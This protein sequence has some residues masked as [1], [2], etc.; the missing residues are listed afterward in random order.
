VV[1]R[2]V[3]VSLAILCLLSLMSITGL[4]HVVKADGG[5]IYINAD[6]SISPSTAPIH[7]SDN[8]TYSLTGDVTTDYY[9]IV[10]ERGNVVLDGAGYTV[11]ASGSGNR[12]PLSQSTGVTISASTKNVTINHMAIT[13]FTYGIYF[14]SSGNTLSGNNVTNNDYGIFTAQSSNNTLSGNNVTANSVAGIMFDF[15]SG[16]TLSDNTVTANNWSILLFSSSGFKVGSSNNTLSG[17]YVANNEYG[18]SLDYFAKNNVLSGNNVTA[19][20]Y[21][22]IG[23]SDFSSGNTLSGNYLT[24]NTYDGIDIYTSSGNLLSGN[25]VTANKGY[26]ISIAFSSNNT[27]SGNNFTANSKA[28]I[29]LDNYPN[30]PYPTN[31]NII[32]G[33]NITNNED[34]ILLSH[35]SNNSVFHNSFV[36]NTIQAYSNDS[37]NTWDNGYPSGGNYWSDY[38]GTDLYKGAYQNVTGSDEIGDSPYSLDVSNIDHYPLMRRWAPNMFGDINDDGKVD[39]LDLVLLAN[40]YGST[41]SSA[42]WNPNADIDGNGAVGLSDLAILAQH[43]GQHYP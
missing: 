20:A 19:N 25:N 37:T 39:L 14:E 23:I 34:G 6:G 29:L 3:F 7:T 30:N 1:N 21:D 24:A 36:N 15:S 42:K 38:N 27:L 16:N 40:A 31:Y 22:G 33:N 35:S 8:V 10:I 5:T 2:V 4:V 18:I 26:G 17:N 32:S 13:N 11:T 43:Y 41:S 9:G 12:A 28:G